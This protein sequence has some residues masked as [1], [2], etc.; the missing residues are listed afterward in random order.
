MYRDNSEE[1]YICRRKVKAFFVGLVFN[2]CRVFPVQPRKVVMW[3]MEGKGGYGDSPKYIAE[4]MIRRNTASVNKFKIVWLADNHTYVLAN[5]EF[6]NCIKVVKSSLWNRAFQLSTAGFW[7]GNTRTDYGTKKRRETV[8]IQT[9]HSIAGIKPIGKQ[10]GSKLPQMARIVSESDSEMIDYVLSGNEW[11]NRMWPDGL[12][13][14]GSILKTGIPRCDVLF[15]GKEQMHR[16]YRE[17]YNLPGDS[18]IMLYAPTFRGGSQKGKRSVSAGMCSL[19][20]RRLVQALEMKFGGTWYIFFRLHPQV[21]RQRDETASKAVSGC[22]SEAINMAGQG[23]AS[24]EG[25]LDRLIDVSGYPDM[26]EL[27]AA[28]DMFLTDYSSSI[29]ESAIMKQPSFLFAEDEKEYVQDRGNLMFRLE[30]MPFPVAYDMDGLESRIANFDLR[31]YEK[32]LE[33]FMSMLGIFEDGNAS[34]RVVDFMEERVLH[35]KMETTDYEGKEIEDS[36]F[37]H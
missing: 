19:N 27:I 29:F 15:H 26:N 2:L 24:T 14:Y 33:Q 6:P 1:I 17:K 34:G 13:Y 32:S 36:A 28:S 12:L 9:W 20:F 31:Q 25:I 18:F 21:A 37:P 35:M 7:V 8:Y 5:S 11:S 10:R 16:K 23:M 3:T 22:G 4:E 30:D